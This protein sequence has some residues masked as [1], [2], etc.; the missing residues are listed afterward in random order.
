[1]RAL[2]IFLVIAGIVWAL[3]AFNMD[4]TVTTESQTYG[5]GEYAISVPSVTVNNLGLMETRRNNLMFAGL[6]ILVGVVLIGFGSLSKKSV[7]GTVGLRPCPFC[8]EPIQPTALKCRYCNSDLPDSFRSPAPVAVPLTANDR[9]KARMAV[10]QR[11]A[12]TYDTYEEVLALL[13]GSITSKGFLVDMHYVIELGGT[14]SRV[15]KF[16]DLR[17]WFLDNVAPRLSA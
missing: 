11:G 13:G 12:A 5:S 4:T 1:M 3:I 8:S 10:V 14:T 7:T 15:D 17:Q 9:V 2:G 16:E 6:T